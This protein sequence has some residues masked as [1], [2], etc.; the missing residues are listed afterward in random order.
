M[1]NTLGEI[2][3]NTLKLEKVTLGGI[4]YNNQK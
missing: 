4:T 1:K 2:T 3:K